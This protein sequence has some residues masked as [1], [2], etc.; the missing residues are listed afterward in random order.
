MNMK[1]SFDITLIKTQAPVEHSTLIE[2]LS[3]RAS[4]QGDQKAYT[5]LVDGET[6]EVHLTY[7]QLEQQAKAIAS[8]LQSLGDVGSRALLLY[9]PGLEF[10]VGF[11]GCLYAGFV[12]VP[13][14]PPRANQS[15]LRLQA[16]IA[17]AQATIVLTTTS[18][19]S[20]VEHQ[21]AQNPVLQKLHWLATDT[22]TN[23]RASDWRKLS[24]SKNTLAF[25]QYTSGSTGTPKGVI[26]SHGNLLHNERM[27]KMA[28]GHTEKTIFVGWLPLFHDMGLIGNVLQP[29][30]LGIPCILMSPIAFLQKPFRWLQAISSYK[31]TTSGGPN[32]AYDMCVRKITPE[33]CESLDLSKWEVAFNGAETIRAQTLKEFATTFKPY[34]FR[35]E[36]FYPCYGMAEAT[37]FVSGQLKTHSPVL[38]HLESTALEQNQVVVKAAE[39][40]N[41]TTIVGCGQTW[42]DQKIAIANPELLTR[43]SPEQVGEIWVSG[44]SLAQGYWNRPEDTER[45]FHE[46]LAD[47]GEGPFLRTGDLGFLHN[48]ELFITGRIKDLII[49]RGRNHYPQDIEITVEQSNPLLRPGACAAFS[50][51]VFGEERLVVAVEVDRSYITQR[52]KQKK[53][54]PENQGQIGVEPNVNPKSH[55]PMVKET[56]IEAI[57]QAVAEYHELQI[58]AVLL[59]KPGSILKTSSGKIQR[60]ACRNAFLAGSLDVVEDWLENPPPQVKLQHLLAQVESLEQQI[61]APKELLPNLCIDN[62]NELVNSQK[63]LHTEEFIQAWLASQLAK[64]LKVEPGD[65]DV[66]QPF[67]RYG[68]DSVIA[69]S[70]TNDLAVLLGLKLEATLL[71]D[72]PS[73]EAL[74]KYL[75]KECRLSDS[76]SKI[77]EKKV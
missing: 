73:I 19:L 36:A 18:V 40:E 39:Q 69:V 16:I 51:D 23:E 14:Y 35:E 34:G 62:T 56:P 70:L 42:L 24:F 2:I 7:R 22:I 65:I 59:L 47:T 57:R 28:F 49:I 30:Y 33:Q 32:F 67:A 38:Q 10:I 68:M 60:H 37:L 63:Q 72:Y 58:Y 55:Q 9:P 43:C 17:D 27:V 77:I 44:S 1:T 45:T 48:G 54:N 15:M 21:V 52:R 11:F 50:V 3:W 4:Y 75:A 66:G 29:L 71:W 26:V 25:L 61:K 41:T 46:Y 12:A 13:A 31:A 6:Q 20:N 5:F 64:Y 76:E 8:T 53:S 74:T